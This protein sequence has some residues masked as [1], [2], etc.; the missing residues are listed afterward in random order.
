MFCCSLVLIALVIGI[1]GHF[2][3]QCRNFFRV[4]PSEDIVLDVSSTSSLDTDEALSAPSGGPTDNYQHKQKVL[5]KKREKSSKK[6]KEKKS[7]KKK[8]EKKSKKKK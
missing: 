3:Y 5:K 4:N 1:A 7:K 6:E 8:K 2:T